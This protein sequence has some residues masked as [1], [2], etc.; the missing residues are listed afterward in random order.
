MYLGLFCFVQSLPAE[1]LETMK[2]DQDVLQQ[3]LSYH[4]VQSTLTC[5]D[6][7][8]SKELESLQGQKLRIK[9]YSSVSIH[10][11]T[12]YRRVK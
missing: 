9:E 11:L 1:L 10:K 5:R 6:I 3:V 12:L 8:G 4:V 7:S 2:R